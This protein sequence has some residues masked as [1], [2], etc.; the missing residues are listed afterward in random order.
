[1][2]RSFRRRGLGRGLDALLA[3]APAEGEEALLVQVDPASVTP[4]PEQPRR[5]FDEDALDALADSI[6]LHGLL[7]PI[8]VQRAAGGYRL[9]AGERR[10][11]AAQ[12]AS[13]ESIPALVRPE[14]EST[15]HALEMALTENLQRTDL[16]PIEEAAAFA[17]LADAFGMSHEMIALRVGRSRPAVSNAIRLLQLP[18]S[19][20]EALADGR[21]TVGVARAV[22]GIP[23]DRE[24][25][26]I[27]ER[28]MAEGWTEPLMATA[29]RSYH[30]E[31]AALSGEEAPP[32]KTRQRR[33]AGLSPDDEAIRRGLESVLGMRVLIYRKPHG[34]QL[35]I[36]FRSEE[37]LDEVYRRLGGPPL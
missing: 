15:R 4:N 28:A 12:R 27:A 10:L 14:A 23:D 31:R 5:A 32:V 34:G 21:V 13:V 26:R 24:R 16:N 17:R 1:M 18:A 33:M 7:H 30:A 2:E 6:R 8:V 36:E 29:V 19:L 35:T 3:T 20:Q 22:L 11:R 9:I 25:E 37:Q